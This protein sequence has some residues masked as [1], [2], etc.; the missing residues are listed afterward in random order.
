MFPASNCKKT[1]VFSFAWAPT[2]KYEF[3]HLKICG[4]TQKLTT[5]LTTHQYPKF[6]QNRFFKQ[7]N[8]CFT[9]VLGQH[10]T[11]VL[12]CDWVTVC[13]VF[14]VTAVYTS[15]SMLVTAQQTI[16]NKTWNLQYFFVVKT[17]KFTLTEKIH[18]K[19]VKFPHIHFPVF[20]YRPRVWI[21]IDL[22]KNLV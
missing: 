2:S 21:T 9:T 6:S 20:S 10:V 8:K 7:Y 11:V 17:N 14:C 5:T 4:D 22:R 13:A 12:N 18:A 3:S 19:S 1:K 16:W 15:N